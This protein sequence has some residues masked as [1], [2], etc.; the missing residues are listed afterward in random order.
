MFIGNNR[1][2][3]DRAGGR[4][5]H[6]AV[7]RRVPADVAVLLQQLQSG[8]Q[9]LRVAEEP[10]PAK[11]VQGGLADVPDAVLAQSGHD[12]Q[13]FL[14]SFIGADDGIG[15]HGVLKRVPTDADGATDGV[16]ADVP[17]QPGSYVDQ[18]GDPQNE[19]DELAA[20]LWASWNS[21]R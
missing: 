6:T 16:G 15:V 4:S 9:F 20:P 1:V 14:D 7:K 18:P 12:M 8:F 19:A 2:H 5:A 17:G 13:R 3:I 11:L 10:S 21:A